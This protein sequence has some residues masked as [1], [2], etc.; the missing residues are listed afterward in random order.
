MPLLEL[1]DEQIHQRLFTPTA[2]LPE[3]VERIPLK[4]VHLN[5]CPVLVP[6]NTLTGGSGGALADQP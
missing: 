1:D 2:D 4:T 3:G 6:T 5:K